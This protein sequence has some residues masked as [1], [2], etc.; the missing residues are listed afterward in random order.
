VLLHR[1]S[2]TGQLKLTAVISNSLDPQEDHSELNE[3]REYCVH[4]QFF[5]IES[6]NYKKNM[7]VSTVSGVN[8]NS[9]F[10]P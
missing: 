7:F 3:R 6:V 1:L 5:L 8:Q 4:V 9:V 10:V 2:T